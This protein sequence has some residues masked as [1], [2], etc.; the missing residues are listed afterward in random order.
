MGLESIQTVSNEFNLL[1][2][3]N[4]YTIIYKDTAGKIQ[5]FR[6]ILKIKKTKTSYLN[7]Y[8]DPWLTKL[9]FRCRLFTLS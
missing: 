4:L 2:A 8:S 6:T 3:I 1:F 5:V 9:E 7:K